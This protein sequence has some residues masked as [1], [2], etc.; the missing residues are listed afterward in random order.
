MFLGST[1]KTP[2]IQKILTT[3]IT[4]LRQVGNT[5]R[6][7][8]LT[9]CLNVCPL[10]IC[11]DNTKVQGWRKKRLLWKKTKTNFT[12]S[13]KLQAGETTTGELMAGDNEPSQNMDDDLDIVNEDTNQGK[14]MFKALI[15]EMVPFN[16]QCINFLSS[17][18]VYC[19]SLLEWGTPFQLDA[20]IRLIL[21]HT[22]L[23]IFSH[24]N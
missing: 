2:E 18:Q 13:F 10:R 6:W 22:R 14:E 20:F 17:V 24:R 15:G 12:N 4:W 3:T 23:F 21:Y 11:Q 19:A 5:R 9:K 8:N 1:R 7:G 16:S